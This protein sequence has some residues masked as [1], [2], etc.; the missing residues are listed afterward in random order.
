MT[1]KGREK[2]KCFR[3]YCNNCSSYSTENGEPTGRAVRTNRGQG[4]HAF[5]L[6]NALKPIMKPQAHN[7]ND[8]IPENIPEN[9]MAPQKSR[10]NGVTWC[11]IF[12]DHN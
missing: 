3:P 5:Q 1:N 10:K 6:E 2:G 9:A 8:G 7:A 12:I 11:F 4:G